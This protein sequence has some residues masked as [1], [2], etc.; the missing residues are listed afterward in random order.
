MDFFDL[1]E[2][3]DNS[4]QG[5]SVRRGRKEEEV[6][7]RSKFD[8]KN[9]D[10]RGRLNGEKLAQAAEFYVDERYKKKKIKVLKNKKTK[11]KRRS[12]KHEKIIAEKN[13]KLEEVNK[14]VLIMLNKWE[15]WKDKYHDLESSASSVGRA[16]PITSHGMPN[17]FM[18]RL[19]AKK[20]PGLF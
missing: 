5:E 1:S 9:H 16:Y 20:I 12:R 17:V 3:D 6:S 10:G 18:K 4:R 19:G 15:K 2:G 7:S 11:W 13:K 14:D 8:V